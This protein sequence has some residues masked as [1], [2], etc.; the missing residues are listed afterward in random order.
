M[1]WKATSLIFPRSKANMETK[2]WPLEKGKLFYNLL[3]T[4]HFLGS[5]LVVGGVFE[6]GTLASYE[7]HF[8]FLSVVDVSRLRAYWV[9]LLMDHILPLKRDFT[10]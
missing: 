8:E 9:I 3:H 5:D 7:K 6:E 2:K 4:I 10:W 1:L